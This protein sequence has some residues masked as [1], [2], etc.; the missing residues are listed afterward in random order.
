MLLRVVAAV[1][2]L[3]LPIVAVNKCCRAGDVVQVDSI[4]DNDLSPRRHFG[5]AKELTDPSTRVKPKNKRESDGY[6][7]NNLTVLNEMIAYN[8]LVDENSHWPP[9]G[10]NSIFSYSLFNESTKLSQS[11]SCVDIMNG[12]YF[13]F[14]CEERLETADDLVDLYKLRKCCEKNHSYDVFKRQCVR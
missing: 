14:S 13:I 8:I 3:A 4:E 6:S 11:A 12:Y 9:C 7:I 2:I 1:A 10:D 5:C